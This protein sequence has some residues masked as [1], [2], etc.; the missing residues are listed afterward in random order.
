MEKTLMTLIFAALV[1]SI[2]SAC[3]TKR[4]GRLQSITEKEASYLTCE[5]VKVEIDKAEH[6]VN[7][8]SLTDSEFTKED[9]LSFFGDL[10]IG[11]KLEYNEAIESANHRLKELNT[12]VKNKKCS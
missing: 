5:A 7:K 3:T 11:N 1:A 12:I 2:F 9:V 6:F 8:V 10:G 4:Y